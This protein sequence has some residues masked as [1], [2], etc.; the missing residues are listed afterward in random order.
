VIYGVRRWPLVPT[1][2][3]LVAAAVMIRLGFWQLDRLEEKAALIARHQQALA[4]DEPLAGFPGD[5]TQ[6]LYRKAGFACDE[7]IGWN[8]IAGRNAADEAGYVHVA[9]C[10][11]DDVYSVGGPDFDAEV[12]IGWSRSP[13]SPDWDGGAVS[14]IIARGGELG[15]RLVANPPQAGLQANAIPDPKDLPNNHLAYAV[16]WFLFAALALVI[17]VLALRRKQGEG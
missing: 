8:A 17:Y 11:V 2:V 15:W 10:E 13:D 7:V 12:V 9:L 6:Y 1:L 4:Q 14:G 3:V 5:G 16:Q